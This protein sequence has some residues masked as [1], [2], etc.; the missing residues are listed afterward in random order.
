MT[1]RL[2]SLL[3]ALAIC[4]L[5]VAAQLSPTA[6]PSTCTVTTLAGGGGV[7]V[8]L[9]DG[10]G[11]AATFYAIGGISFDGSGTLYIADQ[12]LVRAMNA[13]TNVVTTLAGGGRPGTQYADGIGTLASFG[14]AADIVTDAGSIYIADSYNNLIRAI[15]VSSQTVTTLVGGGSWRGTAYGSANGVGSA[16]TFD[17]PSGVAA[18]FA[19]NL[20]VADSRNR[21]IRAISISTKAVTTLAGGGQGYNYYGGYGE[22]DGVGSTAS[23]SQSLRRITADGSGILYVTDGN[24]LRSIAAATK[25]VTTLAGNFQVLGRADGVGSSASFFGLSAV[26]LDGTGNLYVGEDNNIVRKISLASKVVTTM[27]GGGSR[28]GTASGSTNGF[29]SAATFYHPQGLAVNGIQSIYVADGNN[30]IRSITVATAAVTTLAGN[31]VIGPQIGRVD[32]IGSAAT[33]YNPSGIALDTSGSVYIGD[34]FNNLIR[35]I[36]IS[37]KTVSTLAGGGSA[38]GTAYGSADGVG[39]AATFSAPW[40]ISCDL[41]GGI[42][43]AD[44][45]NHLIRAIHAPTKTVTTLA[46]RISASSTSNCGTSYGYFDGVGSTATFCN[47]KGVAADRFGQVYVADSG[48]CL[49]RVIVI[50]TRTVTT[51]AGGAAVF[52]LL[53][54]IAVNSAGSHIYVTE[55][56]SNLISVVDV[57]TRAVATLAGGGSAVGTTGGSADG[58][59]SAA[60]FNQPYGVGVDSTTGVVYVADAKNNLIR[61]INASTRT[62]VT[63]AGGGSQGGVMGGHADGAGSAATFLIPTGVVADGAGRVYVADDYNQLIRVIALKPYQT[64]SLGVS[65]S[66]SLSVTPSPSSSSLPSPILGVSSSAAPRTPSPSYGVSPSS[67]PSLSSSP[68]VVPSLL[69]GGASPSQTPSVGSS[70]STSSTGAAEVLVV[71]VPMLSATAV[72]GGAAGAAAA[73]VIFSLAA[74][75][76]A[77]RCTAARRAD[78][79]TEMHPV[80]A[81]G[82]PSSFGGNDGD[83]SVETANPLSRH[84]FGTWAASMRAAK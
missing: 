52:S 23:F 22:M 43:V 77:R 55:P 76:I 14:Y 58:I 41:F 69:A 2:L 56:A 73:V 37:T 24:I 40:G 79:L 12:V 67:L 74:V 44:M 31:P 35:S 83:A 36:V 64:P 81:T 26:A 10:V 20:Y 53:G 80:R 33:F 60:L 61:A 15:S 1:L 34:F 51:L 29:G 72:I 17:G 21:L 28:N 68:S 59:G 62:V 32:G 54:G 3:G 82:G 30:R 45:G 6:S 46:G 47:P 5:L 48:N 42:F 50:A 49:I 4:E 19:G 71:S 8:E 38:D 57:S 39:S 18:D 63:L 66:T 84:D 7:F 75:L 27:A 25:N 11:S 70:A 16:A 13:A 9:S 65:T 78:K